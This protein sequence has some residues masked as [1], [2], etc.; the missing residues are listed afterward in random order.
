MSNLLSGETLLWQGRPDWRAIARD[1]LHIR[2]LAAYFA[3]ML[4]WEFATDRAD[5]WSPLDTLWRGVGL[6]VAG[7]V[8]LALCAGFAWAIA[9]T[10]RYTLTT[11]RCILNYGVALTATLSVPLRRL[12]SVAIDARHDGK[13]DILL[14]PK[15]GPRL[16]YVNLW[17]HARPWRWASAEP[18][19]RGVPDVRAVAAAISQAAKDVAPGIIHPAPAARI[20]PATVLPEPTW[21]AAGD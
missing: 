16:R 10:T 20:R 17:P 6:L 1:V 7:L 14:S 21:S 19:L 11:E 8:T 15:P 4:I 3:L 18:M 9:R 12:A 2:I 5:G 13:G